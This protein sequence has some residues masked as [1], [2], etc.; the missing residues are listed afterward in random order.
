AT[1]R[2]RMPEDSGAAARE[3]AIGLLAR[4]EH[5]RRELKRKLGAKGHPSDLIDQVLEQLAREGLQSDQRFAEAY[6]HSRIQKG[7]GP[8]RLLHELAERGVDAGLAELCMQS[9]APD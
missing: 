8:V 7:Y 4:R 2:R 3:T 5:S 1:S 9:L 6:L